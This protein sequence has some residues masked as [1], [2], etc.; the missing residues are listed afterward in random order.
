MTR[1]TT[2][3]FLHKTYNIENQYLDYNLLINILLKFWSE[4]MSHLADSQPVILNI[5]ARYAMG[6]WISISQVIRI[7]KLSFDLIEKYIQGW[8]DLRGDHYNNSPI[9]EI[10]I[11]FKILSNDKNISKDVKLNSSRKHLKDT[12]TTRIR[13]YDLPNTMDLRKWG[14]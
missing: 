7:N 9:S 11:M 3:K 10:S 6:E 1:I 14:E 12:P 2:N 5:T 13:G 8:L 4:I